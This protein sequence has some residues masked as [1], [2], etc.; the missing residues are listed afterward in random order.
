[1]KPPSQALI[2]YV[3]MTVDRLSIPPT[4]SARGHGMPV[5]GKPD[6]Q[7]DL[8]ATV[9][10]QLPKQVTPEERTHYEALQKLEAGTK[11]SAA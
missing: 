8:Y 1:M 11:N 10:V 4:K 7:G 9:D 5:P 2:L 6:E 3:V